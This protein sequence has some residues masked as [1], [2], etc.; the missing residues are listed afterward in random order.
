MKVI[1]RKKSAE[2]LQISIRTLDRYIQKGMIN[3]KEIGGRIFINVKDLKPL[4]PKSRF[5]QITSNE[6]DDIEE[7]KSNSDK[8]SKT[9][10][11]NTEENQSSE[12]ESATEIGD[13]QYISS[14]PS[15]ISSEDNTIYEKLY[16]EAVTELKVK[17]ERLEG[18]NYRVG[19]LESQLKESVPLLNYKKAIAEEKN[20]RQELESLISDFEHNTEVLSQTLDSQNTEL[21]QIQQNFQ[22]EK[23]IKNIF[24]IILIILFLLQPFW[25]F[26]PP[27]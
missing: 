2:I 9:E 15:K 17:Q 7:I 16:E 8:S 19:Q 22:I 21:D 11:S 20:K 5:G 27:S 14:T 6:I 18:A 10:Y 12:T 4:I 24:L 25:L 3:K 26:F 1:D 23:N 13:N